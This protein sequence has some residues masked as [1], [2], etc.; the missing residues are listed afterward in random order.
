MN[1]ENLKTHSL[2]LLDH[3]EISLYP[4][5]DSS[6][7]FMCIIS[8]L[9]VFVLFLALI[10][11]YPEFLTTDILGLVSKIKAILNKYLFSFDTFFVCSKVFLN[12]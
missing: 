9:F 10:N 2:F 6:L 5:K 1:Y 3:F 7:L 11:R 4:S 12:F 8:L